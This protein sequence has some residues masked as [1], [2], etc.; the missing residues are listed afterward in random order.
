M[1]QHLFT[2]KYEILAIVITLHNNN[3]HVF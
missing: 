3:N 1:N 2:E